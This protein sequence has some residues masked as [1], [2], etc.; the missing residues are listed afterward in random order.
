MI[1][2]LALVVTS[3]LVLLFA[4]A[5]ATATERVHGSHSSGLLWKIEQAGQTPSYIFGTIHVGD[6]R[7]T[8]L[9]EPVRS[10]LDSASSFSMEV[11]LDFAGIKTMTDAMF[12]GEG[13]SLSQVAGPQRYTMLEQT[14]AR[15]GTPPIANLNAIK[16]WFAIFMLAPPQQD[17]LDMQLQARAVAHGIPVYGLETVQEQIAVID[18]MAMKDQIALLDNA[19]MRCDTQARSYER[20]IQAYLT[21]DLARL[22]HLLD[23]DRLE[24]RQLDELMTYRMLTSRNERMA[25]R[26]QSQLN[27]GNAFIAIGAG[28][29][30]G[31]Q[32]VLA[33]LERAGWQVTP[34]Y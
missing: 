20:L 14:L 33:L 7:V 17:V 31:D 2:R 18:G 12:F 27:N 15:L 9:P 23:E 25:K 30:S 21:R 16:P 8:A 32:G 29:L 3:F 26:M 5:P 11:V 4:V 10:A 24:D 19:I 13:Q 34:V 1:R 28:H 6:P 22:Q